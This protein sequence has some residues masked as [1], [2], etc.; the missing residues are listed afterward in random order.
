MKAD[1]T[2]LTGCLRQ[3]T[4]LINYPEV[5]FSASNIYYINHIQYKSYRNTV[6][7]VY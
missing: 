7:C 6:G 5:T 1:L 4:L 3:L 2:L